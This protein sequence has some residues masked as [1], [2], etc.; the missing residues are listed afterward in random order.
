MPFRVSR[1]TLEQ[2]EWPLLVDRL[3][4]LAETPR[5][6]AHCA[7]EDAGRG[8]FEANDA[9]VRERLAETGEARALLDAGDA[10]S[11]A[12]VAD[13]APALRRAGKGG[14]LAARELLEL[15]ST[16]SVLTATRRSLSRSADTAARL[17]GLGERIADLRDLDE[18]IAYS[19][20]PDGEVRD[21]ASAVL[22]QARR[23][24]RLLAAS[25]KR[26]LERYLRNPEVSACL[27]DSFYTVRN[28][29]YVLPVRAD[30]RGGVRGIV[31]DASSTGTTLFI[32]PEA[33]V[34]IN[35]RLKTA[36]I[37]I[38]RETLRVLRG[39]AR[40]VVERLPDIERSLEVAEQ[41]DLAFAR[42]RL[43]QQLEAVE[44]TLGRDGVFDLYGLRHPLLP[45]DSVVPN[46]V[47]L[48]DGP[49][50]MVVSGPNAGGKT[51]AMKA[52]A[53]AALS[54]R[55][56]LHV[57]ALPGARLDLVDALLADIGDEQD[58][59]ENLSTFSAH[60]ANVARIVDAA[61]SHSLVI[62][63]EIGVGTDPSEG[64]SLAQAILETL[65]ETGARVIATTHYSLLKEMAS[66]DPRF[67]NASVE[68]DEATLAPT[69]RLHLGTPGSSSAAAVA[70]RMGLRPAVLERANALL[71][72]EDRH[73]DR[74]LVELSANRVALE[75]ER[76]EA[77][78][79]R[80]ESET[81]RDA[82]RQK[83][84]QLQERRDK[85]F[86]SLRDELE[87]S[88]KNAHEEVAGVIRGLQRGPSAR[89]A[90]RARERLLALE[91]RA[92]REEA[93]LLGPEPEPVDPVDWRKAKPG[94]AVRVRGGG[95]A[96]LLALPDRRGR[97]AV[98]IGSAR[99]LLPATQLATARGARPPAVR[100]RP[101]VRVE[102][103]APAAA[104]E[105][106]GEGTRCDLRGMRVEEALDRVVFA[107]DR[108]ASLGRGRLV[109]IHGAGTGALRDAVR[110]YLAESPYVDRF[111]PGEPS[112]G[113]EGVT[114]AILER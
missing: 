44:P 28:D 66:V 41:I 27:S 96:V 14:V 102:T 45:A 92:K 113:G 77:R 71:E 65:A 9:G 39:L 105:L 48:G 17:A 36:E 72:R 4:G 16:L 80:A 107:L 101:H 5:G 55:A 42:G 54:V 98:R 108:A 83:L 22:A 64:A 6:R 1:R 67:V 75:T 49:R 19:I 86:R 15:R 11:L 51:V 88:F 61:S 56:G 57:A 46:D 84:E 109:L 78:R 104:A 94:D 81:A 63:D 74:L 110:A 97:V 62:L 111:A 10:P 112:E 37:E 35:N 23:D 31:H 68:L 79:L 99:V 43:S 32:E 8:L 34:D 69:Y 20:D 76:R 18:E 106:E 13:L 59:R 24:A 47:R 2:L 89:E 33:V 100:A 93:A 73:L 60:M 26:R 58:L 87:Q 50:V 29:R 114:I 52:V 85:L 30:A 91:D 103:A 70:A 3:R 40:R 12:G 53:M 82:Y 90:A 7:R 38:E 21:H 25:L 95:E